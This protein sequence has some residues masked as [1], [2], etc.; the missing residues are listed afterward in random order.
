MHCFLSFVRL[1]ENTS[2]LHGRWPV[3]PESFFSKGCVLFYIYK[4]SV[5]YYLL[6]DLYYHK[7]KEMHYIC[8][9]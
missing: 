5:F 6:P 9:L 4:K 3:G 1:E 8:Q 2:A 7:R